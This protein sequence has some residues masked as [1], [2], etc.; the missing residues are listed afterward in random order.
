MTNGDID[1][2]ILSPEGKFIA[3]KSVI[4]A[5]AGFLRNGTVDDDRN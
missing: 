5:R 1:G 2:A 4:H 3:V